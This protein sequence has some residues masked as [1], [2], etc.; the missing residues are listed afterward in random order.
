MAGEVGRDMEIGITDDGQAKV[1]HDKGIGITCHDI[2]IGVTG[3][4]EMSVI[5]G[6]V[7]Q[8]TYRQR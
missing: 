8:T 7:L 6:Q 3:G 4:R 5:R 2:E 1:S